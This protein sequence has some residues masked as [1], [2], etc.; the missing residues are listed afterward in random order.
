MIDQITLY[1]K[2]LSIKPKEDKTNYPFNI[3][4]NIEFTK[5]QILLYY[6]KE[7]NICSKKQITGGKLGKITIICNE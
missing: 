5:N 4:D 6:I 7:Y 3:K 2:L 1:N